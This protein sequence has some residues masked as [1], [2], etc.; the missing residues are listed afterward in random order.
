MNFVPVYRD[1]ADAIGESTI[2]IQHVDSDDVEKSGV[3]QVEVPEETDSDGV[4]G[5]EMME[6]VGGK[7]G[8]I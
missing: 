8:K 3:R 1:T 7:E 5:T 6:E 2:G 4:R